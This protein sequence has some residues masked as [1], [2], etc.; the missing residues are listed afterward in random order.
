MIAQGR[1]ALARNLWLNSRA[2]FI[3][4]GS[5]DCQ[6]NEERTLC[7][8]AGA[9]PLLSSSLALDGVALWVS[10]ATSS[11]PTCAARRAEVELDCAEALLRA[12]V[13]ESDSLI[14][15][16]PASGHPERAPGSAAATVTPP[17]ARGK[18]SPAHAAEQPTANNSTAETMAWILSMTTSVGACRVQL[19]PHPMIACPGPYRP[20][21]NGLWS[22]NRATPT[23]SSRSTT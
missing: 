19:I 6:R 12:V 22:S 8:A 17:A 1:L 23:C 10:T 20:V 4:P 3:T 16:E 9:P 15:A 2:Y 7:G 13:A 5:S 14:A 11:A 21:T 18:K